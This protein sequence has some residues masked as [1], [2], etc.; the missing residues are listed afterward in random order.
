MITAL[1]FFGGSVV[2][3]A[4]FVFLYFIEDAKGQRVLLPKFRAWLDKVLLHVVA[5]CSYTFT[6][7]V[8]MCVWFLFHYGAR[9]LLKRILN[10]LHSIEVRT[11]QLLRKN[12]TIVR[13]M[14][15]DRVRNHLDELSEHKHDSAL[16]EQQREKMNTH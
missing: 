10:M 3:T 11:E 1:L 4:L 7:I 16:T 5:Y 6:Y 2:T 8:R 12:K 15:S 14:S 9:V 13:D